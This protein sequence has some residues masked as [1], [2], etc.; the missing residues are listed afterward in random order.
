MRDVGRATSRDVLL[1]WYRGRVRVLQPAPNPPHIWKFFTQC[2]AISVP[3]TQPKPWVMLFTKDIMSSTATAGKWQV[4]AEPVEKSW[5]R[6]PTHR[7]LSAGTGG[8]PV[9]CAIKMLSWETLLQLPRSVVH[10][11]RD[12]SPLYVLCTHLGLSFNLLL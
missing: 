5:R 2:R 7:M 4:G 11:N 6:A 8:I 10:L 3:R 12:P 1:G 9:L